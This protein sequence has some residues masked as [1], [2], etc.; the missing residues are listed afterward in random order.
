MNDDVRQKKKMKKKVKM[1]EKWMEKK[2]WS[3]DA[4]LPQN[5][6]NSSILG[7]KQKFTIVW[8]FS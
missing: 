1:K 7:Q 5:H 8:D 2:S 4:T 6:R 3:S